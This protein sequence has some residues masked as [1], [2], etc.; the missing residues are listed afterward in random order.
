MK[1]IFELL[2]PLVLIVVLLMCLMNNIEEDSFSIGGQCNIK[3][4]FNVGGPWP[5]QPPP[6]KSN[7]S[8]STSG[9]DQ[10]KVTMVW[11]DWCGFS[12]KAKPEWDNLVKNPK[13]KVIDG[14]DV[15][16]VDAEE[17]VS[18]DIIKKFKTTGFP[19]YYCELEG[20]PAVEQFNS[21]TEDDMLDKI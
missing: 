16:Y 11:A 14:C 18:P 12:K 6:S 8:K 19:T 17:K 13:N 1:Q 21:I 10:C 20:S 2:I 5:A 15:T 7:N 4:P 9:K 3:E